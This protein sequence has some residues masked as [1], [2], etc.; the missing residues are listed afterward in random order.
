M[1]AIQ[2]RPPGSGAPTSPFDDRDC[3][4][5]ILVEGNLLED[6]RYWGISA[7]DFNCGL[8]Y[9]RPAVVL[10][11]NRIHRTRERYPLYDAGLR[12]TCCATVFNNEVVGSEGAGVRIESAYWEPVAS[13]P[14]PLLA[15]MTITGSAKTG[16]QMGDPRA[17]ELNLSRVILWSNAGGDVELLPAV[18]DISYTLSEGPLPGTGN[19]SGLDPLFVA[20]PEGDTYLSQVMAGQ[21]SDS[22]A[23]DAGGVTVQDAGLQDR[24]TRTD[25]LRD[26]GIADMGF[27]PE[28]ASFTL[29]R[30]TDPRSLPPH[31]PDVTLPVWDTGAVGGGNPSLLFYR[32]DSDTWILVQRRGADI[33]VRFE[34]QQF[35]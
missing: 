32:V 31:L 25:R 35:D 4:V 16:I 19:L 2:V 13:W 1:V 11:H 10:R 22:P 6:N 8:D 24:T 34:Y 29:L 14:A 26:E 12:V 33:E 5:R 17:E 3:S 9:P 7:E 28:P 21:A 27:H 30:G 20:G 18:T 23:V 15:N